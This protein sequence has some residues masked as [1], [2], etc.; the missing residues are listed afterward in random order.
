MTYYELW[1]TLTPLYE[2][3]E[4]KAIVRMLLEDSYE[5]SYTDIVCSEF[6]GIN[7]EQL[8]HDVSLLQQ[9]VPVQHI[10]GHAF[11]CGRRFNVNPNVLIPRPETEEIIE[12]VKEAVLNTQTSDITTK[13]S[14]SSLPFHT[15]TLLDIGTGSGCIAI[16]LALELPCVSVSAMDISE[17]ALTTARQNANSLGAEVDFFKADILNTASAYS[18]SPLSADSKWDIIVSNPPYICHKE[19][20]AMHVNVLNNEPHNALFVPDDNPLLFYRAI[21]HYAHSALNNGGLLFFE[22]NSLYASE[23][24]DMLYIEHFRSV[25]TYNDRFGKPR[26]IKASI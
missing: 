2:D 1:R 25:D 4:A 5:L 26:F 11:F 22:I 15:P 21:A 16:T 8:Q 14:A 20:D 24:K 7:I 17:E 3:A 23:T 9:G 10:L 18:H 12:L 6:S 13:Y 19:K